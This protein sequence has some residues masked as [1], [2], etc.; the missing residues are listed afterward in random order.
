[1]WGKIAIRNDVANPRY[2]PKPGEDHFVQKI[3]I[4]TLFYLENIDL[5]T[6][7]TPIFILKVAKRIEESPCH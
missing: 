1:M 6:R 2:Q 4:S 5:S 7:P 3:F